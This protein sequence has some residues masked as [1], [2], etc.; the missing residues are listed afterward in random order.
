MMFW[1]RQIEFCKCRI[2]TN[3]RDTFD[4]V[5]TFSLFMKTAFQGKVFRTNP[6]VNAWHVACLHSDTNTC[7]RQNFHSWMAWPL[8][9]RVDPTPAGSLGLAGPVLI[10]LW[11]A[12]MEFQGPSWVGRAMGI[13]LLALAGMEKKIINLE[14]GQMKCSSRW[15]PHTQ[16]QQDGTDL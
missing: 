12:P 11:G 16:A 3:I 1:T 5:F 6:S 2:N 15:S 13:I 14:T 7:P 4:F 8:K 9:L 10:L